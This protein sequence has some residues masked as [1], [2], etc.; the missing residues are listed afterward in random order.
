MKSINLASL[1][2]RRSLSIKE[3]CALQ[4]IA[5]STFYKW[6]DAGFAPRTISVMGRVMVTQD[7]MRAW[8]LDR[9]E[10]A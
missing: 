6:R 1:K 10:A 5:V 3:F 4:G 7:A 8:E 2:D 9:T